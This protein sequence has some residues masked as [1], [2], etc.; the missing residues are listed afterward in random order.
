[1]AHMEVMQ[2]SLGLQSRVFI[3]EGL[4]LQAKESGMGLGLKMWQGRSGLRPVVVVAV[5]GLVVGLSACGGSDDGNSSS[6]QSN[7]SVEGVEQVDLPVLTSEDA[8]FCFEL[9][10]GEEDV[11][12]Y[13]YDDDPAEARASE[14]AD[15]SNGLLA[16]DFGGERYGTG[17]AD[18]Y[19]MPDADAASEAADAMDAEDPKRTELYGNVIARYD[20]ETSTGVELVESCLDES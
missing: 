10:L 6:E 20:N 9:R 4:V 8:R 14:Q 15:D 5:V 2:R 17:G 19:F 3:A 13:V 7:P 16:V 18:L 11:S 1:M 12:D